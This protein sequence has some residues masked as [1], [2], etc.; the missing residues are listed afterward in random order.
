MRNR[1]VQGRV[2]QQ[3]SCRARWHTFL[4]S[5]DHRTLTPHASHVYPLSMQC[6]GTCDQTNRKR[7]TTTG[8]AFVRFWRFCATINTEPSSTKKTKNRKTRDRASAERVHQQLHAP[9]NASISLG[10]TPP[11][12]PNGFSAWVICRLTT[13][14]STYSVQQTNVRTKFRAFQNRRVKP[15]HFNIF[16]STV[17]IFILTGTVPGPLVC[18]DPVPPKPCLSVPLSSLLS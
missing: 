3:Y 11:I 4:I 7:H 14:S 6:V 10:M 15:S 8:M 9:C 17:S 18:L 5:L 1:E 16:A 12:T 2:T 13:R